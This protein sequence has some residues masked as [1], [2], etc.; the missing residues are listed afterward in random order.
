MHSP[1]CGFVVF[2]FEQKRMSVVDFVVHV[3]RNIIS[4]TYN[5][6]F[7]PSDTFKPFQVDHLIEWNSTGLKIY[8]DVFHVRLLS[9][10]IIFVD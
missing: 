2:V 6:Q 1:M 4:N 3:C 7:G 5:K 9:A 8:C 10:D